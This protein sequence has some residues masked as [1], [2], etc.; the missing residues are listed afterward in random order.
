MKKLS[1][2]TTAAVLTIALS[3]SALAAP[4]NQRAID[5]NVTRTTM[6]TDRTFSYSPYNAYGRDD[7]VSQFNSGR[8][9]PY[10]DRPYGAPDRD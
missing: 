3:G 7:A 1:L 2:F 6:G 5:Q 4:R 9:L 10:P 8:N